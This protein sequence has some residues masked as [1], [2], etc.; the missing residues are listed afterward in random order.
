M[1]LDVLPEKQPWFA[2]GLDFTCT[3]CGN[4]CTGPPGYVHLTDEELRRLANFLKISVEETTERYCRRMGSRLSLKEKRGRGG[5]DCIFLE[6]VEGKR[7]CTVYPVRPLQCRTWPFWDGNLESR[8]NW[9]VAAKR[10][11]GMNRGGRHF[12]QEQI[13]AL[14]DAQDW[15]ENPPTSNE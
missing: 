3:Q 14:R 7:I 13:E 15:P 8:K 6:E 11:P 1:K 12:A 5:W 9:D 10:C 2:D 4:C